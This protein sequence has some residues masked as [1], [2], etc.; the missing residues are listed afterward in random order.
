M[1]NS[2]EPPASVFAPHS[3][4]QQRTVPVTELQHL[5]GVSQPDHASNMHSGFSSALMP[6]PGSAKEV[7]PRS[8]S[9]TS[10]G[11]RPK[12]VRFGDAAPAEDVAAPSRG[13]AS[14]EEPTDADFENAQVSG[15]LRSVIP[16]AVSLLHD[17]CENFLRKLLF[18]CFLVYDT[19][20]NAGE[21]LSAILPPVLSSA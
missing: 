8:D 18:L 21:L 12:S 1:E 14:L 16:S 19:R 4:S 3:K 7:E 5:L 2:L 9:A 11:P 10:G 15:S 6:R 13:A 17:A 20:R